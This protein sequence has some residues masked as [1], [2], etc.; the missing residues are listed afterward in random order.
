MTKDKVYVVSAK[1]ANYLIQ[2]GFTLLDSFN[3][4]VFTFAENAVLL[5]AIYEWLKYK[6]A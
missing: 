3:K 5:A 4:N 2:R 6:I 1:L